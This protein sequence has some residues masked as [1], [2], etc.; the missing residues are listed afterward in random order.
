LV[1]FENE[2]DKLA[3]LG[4]TVI[5]AS[6][7]PED[8]A[9]EVADEVSFPVAWGVTRDQANMLGSWWEDRRGIVQPSEFLVGEDGKVVSATYSSGPLGRVAA[10]DVIRMV[11]RLESLKNK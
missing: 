2:M 10:A 9:K 3:E 1:G 11:T 7:D 4:V 5:A 8:K 6:V